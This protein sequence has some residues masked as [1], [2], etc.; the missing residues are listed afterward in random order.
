MEPQPEPRPSAQSPSRAAP[1][2]LYEQVYSHLS[3][4]IASGGYRSGSRLPSERVL[5]ES[6]HV[7]RLTVRR[8]L[9]EL[10]ESGLVER[11]PRG[12]RGW[13]VASGPL[14]EPT[15]QLVSFSAVAQ[16]R[17]LE[18]TATVLNAGV[19]GASVDEAEHLQ[20]APGARLFDLERLRR[21]DGV[22][23]SVERAR[24]PF[25]RMPWI[26]DVDFSTASLHASLEEHGIVP[27]TGSFL[28][29]VLD[30]DERLA[31]LLDVEL[32]KGLLLSQGQTFDQAGRPLELLWIAYRADRYRLRTTVGRVPGSATHAAQPTTGLS[33]VPPP[34]PP[35]VA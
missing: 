1:Q 23:I 17:G 27:T 13:Y 24:L 35:P 7:S 34:P 16:A 18:P 30:A 19:R 32:G 5:Q 25:E 15:N 22:V 6:L 29:E 26:E 31:G 21:L 33:L 3:E 8:A 14:N 4:Q 9:E 2:P 10:R 11:A 20:I 28:V 12:S